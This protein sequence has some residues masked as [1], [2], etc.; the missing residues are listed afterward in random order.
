MTT[1][2]YQKSLQ[3]ELVQLNRRIDMMIIRGQS[4]VAESRKHKML[5]RQLRAMQ[6]QSFFGRLTSSMSF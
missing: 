1:T 2:Q 6:G 3:R 5:L 4:Y